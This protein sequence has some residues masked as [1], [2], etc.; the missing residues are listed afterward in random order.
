MQI[1]LLVYPISFLLS[2][3]I[4]IT[5]NAAFDTIVCKSLIS[6]I[7]KLMQFG[8]FHLRVATLR[9]NTFDDLFTYFLPNIITTTMDKVLSSLIC[10]VRYC[11]YNT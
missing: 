11:Y 6:K 2:L 1:F 10:I 8:L 4:L 7:F 9:S 3:T 5:I